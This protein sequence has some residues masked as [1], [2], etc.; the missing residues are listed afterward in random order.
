METFAYIETNRHGH[1]LAF[2]P[3]GHKLQRCFVAYMADGRSRV[4]GA[5][6]S[7]GIPSFWTSV[8]PCYAQTCLLNHT[9]KYVL[10]HEIIES[11][12]ILIVS[13]YLVV[14]QKEEPEAVKVVLDAIFKSAGDQVLHEILQDQVHG[15]H[16]I[17]KIVCGDVVGPEQKEELIQITRR[18]LE[19]MKNTNGYAYRKL[20]EVCGLPIPTSAAPPLQGSQNARFGGRNSPGG[21]RGGH[22]SMNRF[23][24][25]PGY[26]MPSGNGMYSNPGMMPPSP[27]MSSHPHMSSAPGNPNDVNSLI[28][29]IQ[30]FQLGQGMVNSGGLNPALMMSSGHIGGMQG[31]FGQALNSN[32]PL[33]MSP[34]PTIGSFPTPHASMMS[35]N[36]DPFN[37]VSVYWLK[38]LYGDRTYVV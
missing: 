12:S 18:V 6:R 27:M 1:Y 20:L 26:S 7:F 33:G 35:P 3:S 30:A 19:S 31:S 29:S 37:P 4:T 5:I 14:N 34:T 38:L 21:G 36:S 22:A 32:A 15:S 24:N 13:H 11:A 9:A 28:S 25:G 2:S 17:S 8:S 23:S 10:V 16:T